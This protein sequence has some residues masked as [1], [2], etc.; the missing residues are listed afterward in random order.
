MTYRRIGFFVLF[1]FAAVAA[2]ALG[3][4]SRFARSVV[5]LS[6]PTASGDSWISAPSLVRPSIPPLSRLRAHAVKLRL[7]GLGIVYRT[8]ISVPHLPRRATPDPRAVRLWNLPGHSRLPRYRNAIPTMVATTYAPT[9][10]INHWWEYDQATIPGVGAY[11]LNA[12][13]GNLILQAND[14]DVPKRGLD[15]A[16]RRTYNSQSRHDSAGNDGSVASNYGAGWT[17]NWDAHLALS[18]TGQAIL[19]KYGF[20]RSR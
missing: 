20:L 1:A 17:N 9:T 16:F 15:F 7:R 13:T 10:G 8:K 3:T 18:D 14:M 19:E 2:S 11:M 6:V 12:G 5:A 4:T